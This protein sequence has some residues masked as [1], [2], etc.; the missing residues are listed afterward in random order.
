[1]PSNRKQDDDSV[2][3]HLYSVKESVNFKMTTAITYPS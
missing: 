2:T 3:I 1:M